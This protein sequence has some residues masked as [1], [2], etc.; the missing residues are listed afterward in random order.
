MVTK[1]NNFEEESTT[2]NYFAILTAEIRYDKRLSDSEKL[3]YA[4]ITALTQ[5]NGICY[6]SNKYF[7]KNFG[8]VKETISRRISNLAK[9][10]HITV[11]IVRDTKTNEIIRRNIRL[12][13]IPPIDNSVNTYTQN[14][15]D[16]IDG[17]VIE[18]NIKEN[19]TRKESKPKKS[20]KIIP[21]KTEEP[22]RQKDFCLLAFKNKFP[23]TNEKLENAITE[24]KEYGFTWDSETLISK[25]KNECK[26]NFTIKDIVWAVIFYWDEVQKRKCEL[27]DFYK[28]GIWVTKD[29]IK[30]A[31]IHYLKRKTEAEAEKEKQ[32]ELEKQKQLESEH[33]LHVKYQEIKEKKAGLIAENPTDEVLGKHKLF[34]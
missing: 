33:E 17:I 20:E 6:A 9:N 25:V 4:E 11:E 16:P 12:A 15:Q 13:S 22:K 8:V 32:K 23:K 21:E 27:D 10:N 28:K 14:T 5:K 29:L 31:G 24:M 34:E 2:P 1:S 3:L 7:A 19:N 26:D 18:N 30:H